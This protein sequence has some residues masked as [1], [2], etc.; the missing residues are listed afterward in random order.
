MR[1]NNKKQ[2]KGIL[3]GLMAALMLMTPLCFPLFVFADEHAG[4]AEEL[5]VD[6][7]GKGEGY[8]A[9]LYNIENGLPT[10]EANAITGTPEGFIW[11]GGYS[12]LLRYDGNTFERIDSVST[13]IT[14]VVS[15]YVDSKER[16]WVGT[17]DNGIVKVEKGEY[18]QYNRTGGMKSSSI[19]SITEGPDGTIYI[20]TTHGMGTYDDEKGMEVVYESQIYDEYIREL[21]TGPDGIIYGLTQ[22]GAIFTFESGR[23]TGFY[24]GERLGIAN[25]KSIYP[26]PDYEGNLYVGTGSSMIYYGSLKGGMKN[27]EKISVAPLNTVNSMEKVGDIIWVCGDNGIGLY[28]DGEFSKVENVPMNNSIDEM[29]VDY[30]GNVWFTSSRQ[31][32]MKIVANRFTDLFERYGLEPT[33]VNSTCAYNDYLLMGTDTGLLALTKNGVVENIPVKEIEGLPDEFKKSIEDFATVKETEP[34]EEPAEEPAKDE[35]NKEG[36]ENKLKAGTGTGNYR[37]DEDGA[38]IPTDLLTLLDG[39]RIRSMMKDSKNRVWFSTYSGLGLVMYDSG[40]VKCYSSA[41][42]LPSDRVR[43]SFERSDGAVLA[44]C[45]GGL[46]IIGKKGVEDVYNE[47]DGLNNPEILTI[48]ESANGDILLGSDGDGIYVLSG[49]EVKNIG[50]DDGLSSEVV[51]R[52][53]NDEK[54]G[55]LWIITSNSIGYMKEDYKVTT[56]DKFPYSNNFDFAE[57]SRDEIWILSSNGIHVV[58]VEEL[59]ANGEINPVFFNRDSGLPC[60]TTANS[61]SYVDKNG[62]LYLSGTTG[63]AKVNIEEPFGNVGEIKAAVPYV[64]ADGVRLYPDENGRFHIEGSVNKVIVYGY[65]FNYSLMNPEITYELKGFDKHP[66]TVSRKDFEPVVYTNLKGGRYTFEMK[67]TDSMG[68][69]NSIVTVEIDKEKSIY[70]RIW[71]RVLAVVTV[72]ALATGVALIIVRKRMDALLASH[73]KDKLF[74]REMIEAFAKT[75]DMKDKYTNGH[76]ARVA[77]YTVMLAKE[78][79]YDEETVDKYYNIALLHDIGKISI[80]PEVLNK[81]GKLTDEE[82][83]EIKSHS[84]KGYNVLKDI[85]IMPEL[86]IGAGAHHERPDGKGYPKGL[87]GNEIPRV[88]QIIAV[89]DTFDAMYSDRP[90]RKRMNFDKAVSIIKEVSGTQL[91]ADVVDAFL[92]LVDKGEFRA[93]DDVG[94]GSTEDI[95]NIHKKQNEAEAKKHA[96]EKHAEEKQPEEKKAEEK[97]AEKKTTG[98]KNE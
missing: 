81:N 42:G 73:E 38:M 7:T 74:I 16:L 24:D 32:V 92:R 79:G 83:A 22:N 67:L 90:Y 4:E 60:V 86:A 53:K 45:T 71:F 36:E 34:A 54:R 2:S 55:I 43:V 37:M 72:V 50:L 18:T 17:N 15:L 89:A 97:P 39:C 1:K 94:G 33:V 25:I 68:N 61:Y 40:K 14:S 5:S 49:H 48:A 26:D 9:V 98:E 27:S 82:F 58:D 95:N 80:R 11:I 8:S 96:E 91:Q 51:L 56:I 69:G 52:I 63:V 64:D 85:S 41:D 70:E 35:A 23:L 66:T 13:G 47:Q 19:R 3:A 28:Q 77:D 57:N 59:L 46:A 78:L 30:E 10:S 88:A 44:A 65:V 20:A 76:S 12:G 29:F 84:A 6:L 93:P 31:G 75:I 87:K 21:R 62:N